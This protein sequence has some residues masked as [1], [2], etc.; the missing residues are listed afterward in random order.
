MITGKKEKEQ[1]YQ[2]ISPENL[3]VD[4]FHNKIVEHYGF[5]RWIKILQYDLQEKENELKRLEKEFDDRT[6]WAIS[7]DEELKKKN[8]EIAH[9]QM[10]I[11]TKDAQIQNL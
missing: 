3:L 10:A 7:L 1:N 5:L 2:E 4:K 6:K 9:L 8:K 11:Q